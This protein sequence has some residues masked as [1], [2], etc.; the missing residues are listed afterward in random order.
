[1]TS[2]TVRRASRPVAISRA[3]PSLKKTGSCGNMSS[4]SRILFQSLPRRL[5]LKSYRRSIPVSSKSPKMPLV[6]I[7]S[8]VSSG[9]SI[10][11]TDF[12][13]YYGGWLCT[14]RIW[15]TRRGWTS[16]EGSCYFLGVRKKS[17]LRCWWDYWHMIG[18]WLLGSMRMAFRLLSYTVRSF[19]SS[20]N[21]NYL[22][23]MRNWERL[24]LWMN[25]GFS[26]GS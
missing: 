7:L 13:K 2:S 18:F 15:V 1:M 23:F 12:R 21:A 17:V 9:I 11:W 3:R 25:Y 14:S 4:T 5:G 20:S 26:N 24:E 10:T 16:S 22:R 6:R 19:G 8:L